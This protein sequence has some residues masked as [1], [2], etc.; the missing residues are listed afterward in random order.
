MLLIVKATKMDN[1]VLGEKDEQ[2]TES[3]MMM[4]QI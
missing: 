1:G 2:N 3:E 4:I